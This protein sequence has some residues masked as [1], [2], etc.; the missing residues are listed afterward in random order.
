MNNILT[1]DEIEALTGAVS[2]GTIDITPTNTANKN[3]HTKPHNEIISID[4]TNHRTLPSKLPGLDICN[5]RFLRKFR[6]S[7]SAILRKVVEIE[8]IATNHQ[9]FAE[10]TKAI[11]TPAWVNT[12]LM[13]PLS[14][15]AVICLDPGLATNFI[16]FLCGGKGL[17]V[18][19]EDREE[20]GNIEQYL[21]KEVTA[22]ILTDLEDTLS[23]LAPI[24]IESLDVEFDPRFITSISMDDMLVCSHFSITIEET[25]GILSI[26]IPYTVLEPIKQKLILSI[27]H[28]K[29]EQENQF[30]PII[31]EIVKDAETEIC[32][33][34]G[35]RMIS[36]ARF[37]KLK[38]GDI[39]RLD[40]FIGDP[41]DIHIEGK[42]KFL[43]S[44]GQY[45][46]NKAA[47]ITKIITQED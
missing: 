45:K 44:P 14:G 36:T 33:V 1:K 35:E 29:S 6:A 17:E 11:T 22:Q 21:L 32:V 40:K 5:T 34:L 9:S 37:L 39:I 41:L 30:K 8:V 25:K 10:F 7:L 46:G 4:L 42:K 2:N 12:F 23:N 18:A 3:T 47:Q 27:S 15:S 24:R 43:G 28:E 26:A 20:F 19:Y 16:E 13:N 31:T 38:V